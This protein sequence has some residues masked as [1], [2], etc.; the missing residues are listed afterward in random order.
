LEKIREVKKLKMVGDD[1]IGVIVWVSN[2]GW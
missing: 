1:L 2:S